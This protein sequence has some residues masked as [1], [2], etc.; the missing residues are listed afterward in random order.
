MSEDWRVEAARAGIPAWVGMTADVKGRA[1]GLVYCVMP[2]RIGIV[3]PMGNLSDADYRAVIPRLT[4]PDTLA[5][6]DR[7]LALRL[8]AT[9]PEAREGVQVWFYPDTVPEPCWW[10]YFGRRG[11]FF[12]SADVGGTDDPILARV[13]M[14]ASV[15]T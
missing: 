6:F 3:T 13:R 4:D 2:K 1:G 5:G 7:R 8:G 12:L 14:W 9:E 15:A 10:V 11:R